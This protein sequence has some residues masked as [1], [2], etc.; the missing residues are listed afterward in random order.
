MNDYFYRLFS[1][2]NW[3][4]L[5]VGNY[6]LD[7]RIHD[8]NCLK[9]MSHVLHAQFNWYGR[10]IKQQSDLPVWEPVELTA[11]LSQLEENGTL[12]LEYIRTLDQNHFSKPVAYHNLAGQPFQSQIQDMLTH[13]VNHGTHHRG[14]VIRKIRELGHVP[15]NT[16]FIYYSRMFP[17][18]SQDLRI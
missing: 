3:A 6:M 14:Q 10:I 9:L 16:D 7:L 11:L 15:P 12:W 1:F 17:L 4:N 13:V 5:I 2:N 18:N 8:E